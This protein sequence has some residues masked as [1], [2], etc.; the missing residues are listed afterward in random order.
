MIC[1]FGSHEEYPQLRL[2]D[3]EVAERG[4]FRRLI[5]DFG[6]HWIQPLSQN[7]QHRDQLLFTRLF[8]SL[9]VLSFYFCSCS[10]RSLAVAC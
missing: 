3:E 8:P 2:R 1:V 4:P 7:A 9:S 6:V 5:S 10:S